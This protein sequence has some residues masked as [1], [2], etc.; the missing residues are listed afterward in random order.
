V[1]I[2]SPSKM[3]SA[4]VSDFVLFDQVGKAKKFRRVIEVEVFD[5]THAANEGLEAYYLN[6]GG[7]RPWN[8]TLPAGK[9]RLR[10]RVSL[11][12]EPIAPVRFKLTIGPYLIEG[13]V[14]GGAWPT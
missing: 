12:D 8:G 6:P 9:I 13:P 3:A 4:A 7:T 14:N 1:E 10:I 5:R 11:I 2:N